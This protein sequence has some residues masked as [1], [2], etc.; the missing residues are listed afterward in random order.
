M[1]KEP[2]AYSGLTVLELLVAMGV[3][4]LFYGVLYSFYQLHA[5]ALKVQEIKLDVQEGSRLAIDSLVRE[6][7]LAGARPVS[8]T[9]CD[10]FEGILVAEPQQITLQHDYRGNSTG[11]PPDGCPDDPNERVTYVYEPAAQL[12]KRATGSGA[13]QPFI[14]DVPADGFALRYFDRDGNEL[15]T[16]LDSV[17][18]AQVQRIVATVRTSRNHPDPRNTTPLTSEHTSTVF[19]PNPMK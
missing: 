8:G 10:G 6:L 5:R 14:S 15:G 3:A 1:N 12:L 13:P 18:R 7:R 17:Q 11:T 19:L 9:S 4:M 2:P 16:P